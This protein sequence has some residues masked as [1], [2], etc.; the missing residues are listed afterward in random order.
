MQ[1]TYPPELTF[2]D[3]FFVFAGKRQ[4]APNLCKIITRSG[5]FPQ[6][7]VMHKICSV[8]KVQV[9]NP[10][11]NCSNVVVNQF[12]MEYVIVQLGIVIK[13]FVSDIRR[14]KFVCEFCEKRFSRKDHMNRHIQEVHLYKRRFKCNECEKYFKRR[15][16]L[17]KHFLSDCHG[18]GPKPE[19]RKSDSILPSNISFNAP[20]IKFENCQ[21]NLKLN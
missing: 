2:I 6:L 16:H 9:A 3:L 18:K 14:E 19:K 13:L 20:Q 7:Y 1:R 11:C 12:W 10:V 17:N 15:D 4:L 8:N 5:K 21:R